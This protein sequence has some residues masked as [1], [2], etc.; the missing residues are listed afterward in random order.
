M[1]PAKAHDPLGSHEARVKNDETFMIQRQN[2]DAAAAVHAPLVIGQDHSGRWVVHDV[3]NLCGGLFVNQNEAIRF[4]MLECQR[5]PQSVIMLP[6]GI[7][8]DALA[9]LPAGQTIHGRRVTP[10]NAS[11]RFAA[12][13][14]FGAE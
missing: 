14:Y 9:P 11:R 6:N 3:R 8:F 10:G 2:I 7:E 4:A 12:R 5:R 13:R 1:T